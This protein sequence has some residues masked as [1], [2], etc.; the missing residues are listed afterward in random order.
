MLELTS[1]FAV[2]TAFF[3]ILYF[4]LS[5][6]QEIKTNAYLIKKEDTPVPWI[7][8]FNKNFVFVFAVL[9]L[10]SMFYSTMLG[11]PTQVVTTNN[12]FVNYTF[13]T[14]ISNGVSAGNLTTQNYPVLNSSVKS[15]V[16]TFTAGQ[17][18]VLNAY[19]IVIEYM[20]FMFAV[21]QVIIFGYKFLK[22]IENQWKRNQEG[23]YDE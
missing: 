18:N 5:T 4:K 13:Q 1:V 23:D 8:R 21:F 2:F 6:G 11:E 20:L 22:I 19:F 17:T 7:D 12:T 14:L 3:F 9:S 15:T 10:V 16:Y